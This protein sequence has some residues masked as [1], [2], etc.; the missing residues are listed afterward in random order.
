MESLPTPAQIL[1]GQ[2][3]VPDAVRQQMVLL[4][5]AVPIP[6]WCVSEFLRIHLT[7][8]MLAGGE[9]D[10][11]QPSVTQ[12]HRVRPT[13]CAKCRSLLLISGQWSGVCRN[14]ACSLFGRV[15]QG[16]PKRGVVRVDVPSDA[17][18]RVDDREVVSS[19]LLVLDRRYRE[20]VLAAVYRTA[21]HICDEWGWKLK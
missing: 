6:R 3:L 2:Q 4:Q 15:Q 10:F 8:G 20:E 14:S 9:D 1:R 7:P 12:P 19:L 13:Q 11:C 18:T 5:F 16:G 21:G 17:I